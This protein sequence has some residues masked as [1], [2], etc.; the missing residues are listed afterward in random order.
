MRTKQE[1]YNLILNQAK[2][3]PH[4]HLVAMNGSRTNP[5][6]KPDD[7]QD[8]DIVYIV[9]DIDYFLQRPQWVDVFGKRCI[10][11]LPDDMKLFPSSKNGWYAYLML[12]EDGNRIDLTLIPMKDLENYLRNDKL[13]K[14]L[15]NRDLDLPY[16]GISSDIDYHIKKPCAD[17][18]N[19]C[20]NEFWWTTT[21][22]IKGLC[23]NE[24]LYALHHLECCVR[25]Q[26]FQMMAWYIGIETNFSISVGKCFKFL[27]DKLPKE[28][29]EALMSTYKTSTTT[30]CL[31][32]LLT[33]MALFRK[34]SHLVSD[35]FGYP[36]PQEDEKVTHYISRMCDLYLK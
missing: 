17:Y 18:F 30:E 6:I 8:Y 13:L 22:V 12:F 19:D 34:Y 27:P 11:Q 10:M 33:C 15:W 20:C 21:Y 5:N 24:M 28:D 4:V 32:A 25:E 1:M 3:N 2:S 29:R 9:D 36:Y 14:I 16:I 26:L 23:R 7:F 35:H 31:E